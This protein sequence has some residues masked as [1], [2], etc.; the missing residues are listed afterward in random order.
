ML[1][2]HVIARSEALGGNLAV[3]WKT[4]LQPVIA[5]PQALNMNIKIKNYLGRGNPEKGAKNQGK[6]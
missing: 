3:T 6:T 5:S 4:I 1:L 2:G